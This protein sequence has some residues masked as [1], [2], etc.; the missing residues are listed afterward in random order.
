MKGRL[1]KLECLKCG[2]IDHY[3]FRNYGTP[4]TVDRIECWCVKCGKHST[5]KVVSENKK[6]EGM[7]ECILCGTLTRGSVG[8]AGLRWTSI[9]QICKD[10]EDASLGEK[11]SY[12]ANVCSE[13]M[14]KLHGVNIT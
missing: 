9:C 4:R 5:F 11:I 2:S 6:E 12:Q 13:V 14:T 10:R 7:E 3:D 1:F 8:A